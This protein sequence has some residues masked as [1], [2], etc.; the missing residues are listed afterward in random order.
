MAPG[1][2][3]KYAEACGIDTKLRRT[4]PDQADC[5]LRILKSDERAIGPAIDGQSISDD[6]DSGAFSVEALG[7]VQA[8]VLDRQEFIA[9]SGQHH[10]PR[11]VGTSRSENMDLGDGN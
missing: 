3:A 9:T 1:G 6:E 5:A 8:L 11:A 7:R 2:E 10:Q 4:Q